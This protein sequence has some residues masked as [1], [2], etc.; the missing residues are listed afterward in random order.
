[1]KFVPQSVMAILD[2]AT[3]ALPSRLFLH[4]FPHY[5]PFHGVVDE[6]LIDIPYLLQYLAMNPTVVATCGPYADTP[7]L[8]LRPQACGFFH[9]ELWPF[10][11][12][13][14]PCFPLLSPTRMS[15]CLL[16]SY[17]LQLV[18]ICSH[19]LLWTH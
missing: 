12:P 11:N 19:W 4:F 6:F 16:A 9:L 18:R 8:Q 2:V 10:I 17:C 15:S 14:F 1:M 5:K 3:R 13:R 7:L